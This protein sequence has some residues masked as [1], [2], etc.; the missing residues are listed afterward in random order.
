MYRNNR[1]E[2]IS[3]KQIGRAQNERAQIE[4]LQDNDI[5]EAARQHG[6]L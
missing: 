5:S 3:R 2:N 6:I 4:V 1:E